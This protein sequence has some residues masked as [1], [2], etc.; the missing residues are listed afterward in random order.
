MPSTTIRILSAVHTGAA[1]SQENWRELIQDFF[2]FSD[3]RRSVFY[4][5]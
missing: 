5:R 1:T 3:I 4:W 2:A